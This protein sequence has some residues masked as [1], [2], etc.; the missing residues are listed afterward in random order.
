MDLILLVIV[1]AI[2]G[3]IVWILTTKIPMPPLW[4]T[5]IQIVALIVILLYLLT[6][7]VRLPNVLP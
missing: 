6:R 4:A 3:F 2:L 7:F 1:V 5:V